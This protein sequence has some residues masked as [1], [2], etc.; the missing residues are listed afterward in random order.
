M[1]GMAIKIGNSQVHIF[2]IPPTKRLCLKTNILG[3]RNN[4]RRVILTYNLFP[5]REEQN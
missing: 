2:Y 1:N 5:L 3:K 4:Y